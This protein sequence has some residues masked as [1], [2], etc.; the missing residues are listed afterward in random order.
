METPE[1]KAAREAAEA[2]ARAAGQPAQPFATFESAEAFNR[3]MDRE[4]KSRLKA[5]GIE[6]P[7]KAKADLEAYRQIQAQQAAAEEAKKGEIQKAQDAQRAAEQQ[8]AAMAAENERLRLESHLSRV[9][10]A[11][12]VQNVPYLLFVVGQKLDKLPDGEQLDEVAFI[13]ELKKDPAQAAA[14]GI[15]G[16]QQ[17]KPGGQQQTPTVGVNTTGAGGTPDARQ[18]PA[19]G[20]ATE[21]KDAFAQSPA[22]FNAGLTN[23]YGFSPT[24][25]RS[26]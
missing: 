15:A 26:T 10:A 2:A 6:D 3:R 5:M 4:A 18:Q 7:E 22:E 24:S 12:G 1:E 9:G 17:Q 13:D 23:R 16:A 21:T 8:A 20:G 25:T 14:L 19:G 11:A